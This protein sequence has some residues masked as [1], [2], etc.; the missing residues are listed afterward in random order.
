MKNFSKKLR[1]ELKKAGIMQ[2]DFAK[3]IGV[4]SAQGNFFV[5]GKRT[6]SIEMAIKIEEILK[7]PHGY[8]IFDQIIP[9]GDSIRVPLFKTK[10]DIDNFISDG[11]IQQEVDFIEVYFKLFNNRES[12]MEKN[13]YAFMAVG[14]AMVSSIDQRNSIHNGDQLIVDKAMKPVSGSIV[15]FTEGDDVKVRKYLQDGSDVFLQALN[16]SLPLIPLTNE[17]QL[18]GV[19]QGINRLL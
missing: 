18:A 5:T 2:I 6:P 12:L 13:I 15:I 14:D 11:N 19:V 9:L 8:L 16:S 4:S 10:K 3:M 17:I 1:R 7:L